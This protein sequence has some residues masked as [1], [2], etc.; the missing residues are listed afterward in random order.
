MVK[1]MRSNTKNSVDGKMHKI[2]WKAKETLGKTFK[3][4]DM[5]SAGRNDSFDGKIQEKIGFT[6]K[7]TAGN[8]F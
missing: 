1:S 5:E 3:D 7:L 2:T 8:L 6:Q 4:S